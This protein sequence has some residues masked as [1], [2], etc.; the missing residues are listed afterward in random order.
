M[1]MS[2]IKDEHL[3]VE[4]GAVCLTVVDTKNKINRG[5]DQEMK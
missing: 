5:S 2:V 4:G 1:P 3:L